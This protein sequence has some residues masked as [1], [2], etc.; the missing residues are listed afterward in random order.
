M[1]SVNSFISDTLNTVDAV[2]SNFVNT[3]YTNFVQANTGLITLLFTV[4]IMMMGYQFLLHRHHYHVTTMIKQ[5]IVMLCVYALIMNWNLYDLFVYRIFTDEPNTIANVLINSANGIQAGTVSQALDGIY[6]AVTNSAMDLFNQISFS[7]SGIAFAIYALL[8]LIVGVLMCVYALLLFIY[9]KMMM[10][11]TLALGPIFILFT[12]WEST[13]GLFSAWLNKLTT[14][15]LIP[16]ITSGVLVLMLSVVQ[17]TLSG[18]NQPISSMQFH[19]IAP[20]LGLCLAT[21]L[22]LMQV[23]RICSSLGGGIALAGLGSAA[24]IAGKALKYSGAAA[25]GRTMVNGIKKKMGIKNKAQP[26]KRQL[27]RG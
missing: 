13:Q 11:V 12:L 24:N 5:V 16:V 6:L 8:V 15:A 21:T 4:Y 22:I 27:H 9:S 7:A 17:V 25:A 3:A 18:L 1:I 19:G 23:L 26:V 10:A 20:F 14:I 2:I